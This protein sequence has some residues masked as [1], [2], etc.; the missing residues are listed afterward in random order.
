MIQTRMFLKLL[1]ISIVILACWAP[2]AS[3]GQQ[4]ITAEIKE[5]FH[6]VDG[7]IVLIEGDF[8]NAQA[9][10]TD[11]VIDGKEYEL[12][13]HPHSIRT[14]EFLSLIHI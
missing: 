8:Q 1:K 4:P 7:S 12:E 10:I 14:E 13:L 5:A 2:T 3:F 11:I 9:T 6:L